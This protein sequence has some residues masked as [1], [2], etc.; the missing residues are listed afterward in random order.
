MVE[1]KA[2]ASPGA[3]EQRHWLTD[4]LFR[5]VVFQSL[6]LV[7][8]AVIAWMIVAD[9]AAN[10]ERQHVSVGLDFLAENTGF[11]LAQTLIAYSTA[12]SIGRA[13]FIGFLNTVLV[14]ILGIVFATIIGLVVGIARLST[15]WVISRLATAY[16]E[17]IR[18]IPLLLQLFLWY[19]AGLGVLPE[20]KF[21]IQPVPGWVFINRRGIVFPEMLMGSATRWAVLIALVVAIAATIAVRIWAKRRQAATGQI[22]PIGWVG[23]L[24]IVGLPLVAFLALGAD[25]KLTAPRISVFNVSGGT[26]INP[27]LIAMLAGLTFYTASFIAEAVRSGILAVSHGQIEA[28]KALG[29]SGG[30]TLKLVVMPQALRVII[31]P[32]TNQYLNLTKNS[33]LAV[34]IGYPDLVYVGEVVFSKLGHTMEVIALWM[35][36]YLGTSLITSFFMN[37]YNRRMA[38]VER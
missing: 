4:P 9:T 20:P 36:I 17:I 16:V 38:I 35:I 1:P 6:A 34:A 26:T 30:Q 10:M 23:L 5:S 24:L 12:S 14:A 7:A 33:S 28:S 25:L 31:P 29:L 3:R 13:L 19:F 32:L 2:S 18:N 37:W 27:E 22:F 8:M 21:S 15:N 11:D